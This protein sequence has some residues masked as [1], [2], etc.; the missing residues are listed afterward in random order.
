ML[1]VTPTRQYSAKDLPGHL[2]LKTR[3][4]EQN[5]DHDLNDTDIFR[6]GT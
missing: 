2:N 3:A 4:D 1:I 6:K 5:I